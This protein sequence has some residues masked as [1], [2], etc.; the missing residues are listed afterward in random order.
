MDVST[1]QTIAILG[2]TGKEGKGLAY[3]WT[4]AGYKVLIGSRT[5][6]KA[7]DTAE[8]LNKMRPSVEHFIE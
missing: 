6:S 1:L 5:P 4:R 8:L 7:I 3:R 2:G